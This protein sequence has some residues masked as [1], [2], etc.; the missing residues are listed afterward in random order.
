MQNA[1][2]RKVSFEKSDADKLSARLRKI[3]TVSALSASVCIAAGVRNGRS[4]VATFTSAAQ[5]RAVAAAYRSRSESWGRDT[6]FG[7]HY[8]KCA[9]QVD[10]LAKVSAL[11]ESAAPPPKPPKHS[12]AVKVEAEAIV[13]ETVN[14]LVGFAV[15]NIEG[16]PADWPVTVKMDW[17]EGRTRS[18]GGHGRHDQFAEGRISLAM[19]RYVPP[20]GVGIRE[21]VEYAHIARDTQIGSYRGD[22][23]DCL[24]I[25]C[26]H[27]VAHAVQ[28]SVGRL[29]RM[30]G[31]K[32]PPYMTDIATAHGLGWQVVYR[33]LR[34]RLGL[35][36]RSYGREDGGDRESEAA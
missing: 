2:V 25:L 21:F 34:A 18:N 31:D 22:W 4:L 14:L 15:E 10:G 16:L 23:R 5:L 17:S 26:A 6:H 24:R 36:G 7:S 20:D 28:R 12:F 29:A 35:S 11:P 27:E 30:M 9:E 1:P 19:C 13:R 32:A 8:A 3:G 33:L